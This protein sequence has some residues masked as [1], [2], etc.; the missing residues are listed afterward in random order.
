MDFHLVD[1]LFCTKR[2]FTLKCLYFFTIIFSYLFLTLFLHIL[3]MG[4]FSYNLFF[5][6]LVYPSVALRACKLQEFPFYI[7]YFCLDVVYYLRVVR[8]YKLPQKS[9]VIYVQLYIRSR[10]HYDRLLQQTRS[11]HFLP[12]AYNLNA[13]PY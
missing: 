13:L 11:V 7:S 6:P 8:T 1:T 9:E 10:G 4:E 2:P 3:G 12:R 5:H